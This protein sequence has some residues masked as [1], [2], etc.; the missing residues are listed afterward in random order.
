MDGGAGKRVK[1]GGLGFD[2]RRRTEKNDDEDKDEDEENEKK[3]TASTTIRSK[4]VALGD[5]LL[6]TSRGF[7]A[8]RAGR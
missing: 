4:G 3:H 2:A 6:F 7:R 5:M 8:T 1:L